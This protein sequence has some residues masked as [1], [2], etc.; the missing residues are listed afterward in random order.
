M[1]DKIIFWDLDN[2]LGSF[3][4]LA[5][6]KKNE[7]SGLREGIIDLLKDFVSQ[8]VK[9]YV[10]T[11]ATMSYTKEVINEYNL[12]NYFE[13]VFTRTDTLGMQ[14]PKGYLDVI[15]KIG[16]KKEN[17]TKDMLIVGDRIYDTPRDIKSLVTILD[18]KHIYHDAKLTK[19]MIE[20]LYD[21]GKGDF[22]QGFRN[23]YKTSNK[24]KPRLGPGLIIGEI[25]SK[26]GA[27]LHLKYNHDRDYCNNAPLFQVI[28][29][30]NYLIKKIEEL[31]NEI[32]L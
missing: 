12:A 30:D 25:K 31:K 28:K 21:S 15:E 19:E 23:L 24:F 11:N 10:T 6:Y 1:K 7:Y 26:K 18:P 22:G 17:A 32:R 3:A 13:D 4:H 5:G 14:L 16:R 29:A 2:T 8:G 27:E 9:N 20:M